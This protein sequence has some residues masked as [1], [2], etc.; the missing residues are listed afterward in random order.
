MSGRRTAHGRKVD[1]LKRALRRL[2]YPG[3]AAVLLCAAAAAAL[4]VYVFTAG[5]KDG[6][7]AYASYL[8]S[9]YAL[10]AVCANAV[11]L[12]RRCRERVA[13]IPLVQRYLDEPEFRVNSALHVS[14]GLNALY[15]ALN[16]VYGLAYHSYWYGTLAAYYMFLAVLRFL[17][18]RFARRHGLGADMAGEWRRSRLCG[19]L[20]MLMNV[21]LAGVVVLVMHGDG[22]F[23]YAGNLI[24]AMAL[25]TFYATIMG[26]VNLARYRRYRSP[27]MSAARAVSLASALVSMFALETAMLAQFGTADDSVFRPAMTV[28]T[29]FAVWLIVTA[30]GAG[31]AIRATKA[32]RRIKMEAGSG[33]NV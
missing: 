31:M 11:A 21:V 10:A 1:A 5:E 2:F 27:V 18:L 26:V 33:Q 3:A 7:L 17:L 25:Y 13:R 20:L 15:S 30:L 24:Y 19:V 12:V 28:A 8:F 23:A 14:L 22:G 6:P 29:G 32:L 4:L 16:A 9:A